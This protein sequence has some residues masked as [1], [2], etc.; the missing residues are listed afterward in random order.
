MELTPNYYDKFCCIKDRCKHNCCIGWEIE[1]DEDTLECYQS[2]DSDLGERIRRSIEGEPPRFI[3]QPGDRCPFL[4][5]QG[6]CEIICEYGEDA[7]C[8]I[9]TLHPR[10]RNFFDSFTETGLGLCCE[11]AARIILTGEEPFSIPHP[12]EC[13]EVEAV[14]L[15]RRQRIFEILQ[16]R[17]KT[18]GE[19]F[20]Y[21]AETMGFSFDFSF[22]ELKQ[23]YLSLERMDEHWTKVLEGLEGFSFDGRIF[24]DMEFQKPLEQL[25][26]YFIFRHLTDALWDGGYVSRVRFALMSCFFIGALWEKS[27]QET[28]GIHWESL[29]DLARMYSA[30]IEYS[31]ENTARL[32]NI[33]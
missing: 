4:N 25:A 21:L 23:T 20:S 11:E 7:L 32:L 16:E 6:L 26:V 2:L 3:L 33:E 19:R 14:F 17:E 27:R 8:D 28:G 22:E 12:E 29:I 30:E 24:E 18:M 15:A 1:V 31:E 5:E 10:F 9:C 13:S